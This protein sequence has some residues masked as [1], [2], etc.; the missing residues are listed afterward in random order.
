MLDVEFTQISDP[1]LVRKNNEDYLGHARTDDQSWL[2]AL[3]DGVG[4]HDC[5]EVASRT[6]VESLLAGFRDAAAGESHIALL[7]RL[8]QAANLQV[9]ETG[10]A[11]SPGG[12]PM[13][14]TLVS[15]ALKFD[16]VVVAHVGDSR[17][18]LIRLGHATALTRDH[19]VVADQMR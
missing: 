10:R 4:G 12:V 15:C 3:A 14:T 11:A 5:G 2:F 6:A 17:C 7:P 19:T 1:G 16:R 13:S 9:Y 8:V 18:Y